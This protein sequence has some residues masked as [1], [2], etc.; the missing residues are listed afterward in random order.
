MA[1]DKTIKTFSAID[2]EKYHKGSL[3]PAEMHAIEKAALDDPFLADALEGYA[4]PGTDAVAD[5]AGL[6][7]RL[8]QRAEEN[9]AIPL[10]GSLRSGSRWWKA[11]ALIL[12][13]AGAGFWIYR[14]SF[15]STDRSVATLNETEKKQVSP[16]VASVH[17]SVSAAIN[18]TNDT[19][20]D[21]TSY[22]RSNTHTGIDTSFH[23]KLTDRQLANTMDSLKKVSQGYA[24]M[25]ATEPII[26]SA[27]KKT[28]AKDRK[29]EVAADA[30]KEAV[31]D[32]GITRNAAPSPA[33]YKN[34]QD[35]VTF[36]SKKQAEK[37]TQ[38]ELAFRS[39][40]SGAKTENLS[41]H[42][43]IFRGQVT[44][45][46]NNA[47]PFAN[48]TNTAD[49]VG[50]YTD[51]RG[52]FVLTSPD[53]VLQVQVR[54]IGF[55]NNVAQLQNQASLNHVVMQDDQKSLSEIVLSHKKITNRSRTSNLVL[56][57]PEPVDGWDNYDV[58][59]ANNL[60]VPETYRTKQ[61]GGGEVELSFDVNKAGEPVNIT[62]EKSLCESCDKEAIRLIK[63][64]PKWKRKARRKGRT[65]VT[66]SF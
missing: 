56:E 14:L 26:I 32:A 52:N 10:A 61:S 23:F 43:N 64:G 44:D 28:L 6:K 45:N 38:N 31:P 18:S 9:K 63:E 54:S 17:D 11:A 51:A 27:E 24:D 58:Y 34:R 7:K 13:V 48:I 39:Q 46:N 65:S 40:Q 35:S 62:V 16:P 29:E 5:I 4:T 33:Y 50:T 55:E 49:N 60:S 30:L 53:S 42:R 12:L 36:K 66:I 8:S 19:N 21:T 3:S 22:L 1:N 25:T 41:T 57:E 20:T 59:V 37:N 15:T 2:I 47:V